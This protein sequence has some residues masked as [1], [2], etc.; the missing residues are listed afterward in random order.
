MENDEHENVGRFLQ[1]G[2]NGDEIETV[3]LDNEEEKLYIKLKTER[4]I[5]IQIETDGTY[6]VLDVS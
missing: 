5:T 1:E 4:V 3:Q 2:I 6:A